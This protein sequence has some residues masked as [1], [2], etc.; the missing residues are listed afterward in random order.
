MANMMDNDL[1]MV[2]T[3]TLEIIK[4]FQGIKSDYS[5]KFHLSNDGSYIYFSLS[6]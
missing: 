4:S 1:Y 3:A 5:E 6:R 2:D